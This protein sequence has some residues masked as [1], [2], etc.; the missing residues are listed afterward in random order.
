ML[1]CLPAPG[2]WHNALYTVAPQGPFCLASNGNVEKHI[3]GNI[4]SQLAS[5]VQTYPVTARITASGGCHVT[6][7][8][9]TSLWLS[10]SS[11]YA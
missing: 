7:G 2:W 9:V 3:T 1:R 8:K 10:V 4:A 5:H 11:T 6:L